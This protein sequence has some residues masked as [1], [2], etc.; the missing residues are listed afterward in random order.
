[1]RR[2]ALTFPPAQTYKSPRRPFEAE[3][4]DAEMKLVRGAR[5]ELRL[6]RAGCCAETLNP[7]APP[8][9]G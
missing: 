5:A 9:A 6:L 7:R 8:A 4:L 1:M 2:C 3:R